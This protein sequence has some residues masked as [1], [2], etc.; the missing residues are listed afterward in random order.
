[1]TITLATHTVTAIA[2][3]NLLLSQM[4][5]LDASMSASFG[6]SWPCLGGIEKDVHTKEN[7]EGSADKAHVAED[8]EKTAQS[9]AL[10]D[11]SISEGCPQ[12]R[13]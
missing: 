7:Q 13:V 6:E 11:R 3:T 8:L 4:A 9:S 5:T 2:T 10:K 1:M 12:F